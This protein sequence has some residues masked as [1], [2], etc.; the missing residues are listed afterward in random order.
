MLQLYWILIQQMVQQNMLTPKFSWK[1]EQPPKG[2]SSICVSLFKTICLKVWR[3]K[4]SFASPCKLK[5]KKNLFKFPMNTS[6]ITS[7]ILLSTFRA[8]HCEVSLVLSAPQAVVQHGH[9]WAVPDHYASAAENRILI[10]AD[11]SASL[12]ISLSLHWITIMLL[13]MSSQP[14]IKL[15][16]IRKIKLFFFSLAIFGFKKA[17]LPKQTV[18]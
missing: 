13:R 2:D 1:L 15:Q 9:N 3:L 4:E 14:Q 12:F 18:P 6:G 17:V 5:E 16:I 8:R 10:S 7:S 11:I